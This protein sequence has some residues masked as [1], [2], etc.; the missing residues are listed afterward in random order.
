[1]K[2]AESDHFLFFCCW[3]HKSINGTAT[4]YDNLLTCSSWQWLCQTHRK[5]LNPKYSTELFWAKKSEHIEKVL[6]IFCSIQ[7]EIKIFHLGTELFPSCFCMHSRKKTPFMVAM[8]QHRDTPYILLVLYVSTNANL[9]LHPDWDRKHSIF[10]MFH[11][12][13]IGAG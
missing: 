4:K 10:L 5:G 9:S 12:V 11:L 1:M 7:S 6:I 13:Y 8:P 2:I 3:M